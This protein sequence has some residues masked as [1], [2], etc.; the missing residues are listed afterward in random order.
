MACRI[1]IPNRGPNKGK[2][3]NSRLF[4]G[5]LNVFQDERKADEIYKRIFSNEFIDQFG[6]WLDFSTYEGDERGE[7]DLDINGEPRLDSLRFGGIMDVA[8]KIQDIEDNELEE[9]QIKWNQKTSDAQTISEPAALRIVERLE[10]IFGFKAK[11]INRRDKRWAGKFVADIPVINIAYMRADT[12]FHEFA[13]PWV[14]AI[15]KQNPALFESLKRELHNSPEGRAILKKVKDRYPQLGGNEY[16]KE[17]IVTAIGEYAAGMINE[18]GK[19]IGYAIFE[20]LKKIGKLINRIYNPNAIITPKDLSGQSLRSLATIMVETDAVLATEL[21]EFTTGPRQVTKR[22]FLKRLQKDGLV[23]PGH[24]QGWYG[25]WDTKPGETQI[26]RD[27]LAKNI[28]IIDEYVRAFPGLITRNGSNVTFDFDADPTNFEDNAQYQV[29]ED[30]IA[31]DEDPSVEKIVEEDTIAGLEA[32]RDTE[33]VRL[34][35]DESQYEGRSGVFNR[36][37]HFVK[38]NILGQDSDTV[39][40][41]YAAKRVFQRNRKNTESDSITIDKQEYTF[42]ELVDKFQKRSNNSAARG[43]AVHKIMEY[44]VTKDKRILKELAEIQKEKKDQDQITDQSLQWVWN[45]AEGVLRRIGVT[46]TDKMKAELMLHSPIL[47]IATQI[48]GLI[49]HDDGTLSMVDWKSGG[50]F[51]NDKVTTE[52]MRYSNGT[53][54]NVNNSKLSKAKLELAIRAIMVKEHMPNAKFRQVIVQHLDRNNPFK[55]PYEVHLHDYIKIVSNYLQAEK[56]EVYQRLKNAGLLEANEYTTTKVRN[57]AVLSKYQHLPLEEQI[58]GLEKEI[59]V[60]RTKIKTPGLSSNIY[61]DQELLEVLTNEYLELN[62]I[63]KESLNSEKDLGN[64]KTWASSIYNIASPRI[65]AFAKIFFR[66]TNKYQQRMEDE[67]KKSQKLFQAVK[68]EYMSENFGSQ[69]VGMA[70]LGQLS[71]YSY[72][73]AFS[74]AF[75]NR[76]DGVQTPGVYL[77]SLEDATKKRASGEMTKAQF[78]LLEHLHTT[79]NREWDTL[80][81]KKMESG[82]PYSKHVGMH[83]VENSV[84]DGKLHKNFMPRL[85]METGESYERYQ[86]EG[87]FVK[88]LKGTGEVINNFARNTFSLFLEENYYGQSDSVNA[89]IPVRF[90]GSPGIIADEMHSFNLEKMHYDFVGNLMRKQEMDFVVAL[91]DGLKSYY[92]TMARVK[93][94]DDKGWKNYENFM[95]NFLISSVMEERAAGRRDHWSSKQ[96]SVTNPFFDK[97]KPASLTNRRTFNISP[98]KIMMALK[99]I[100]TGKALFF[101]VIAGTFNGAIILMFT[102]M[103]GVQ[104]SIAKRAGYHPSAI[105]MTVSDLI[106]G[107]T[108]VAGYFKDQIVGAFTDKPSN[109]KLHN[110]LRR[111]KYLP[112]NYDYAIDQS[113]MVFLKN[114]GLSYDKLFFFHAIH[115]EWGHALMLAAQMRRIKMADGTSIWDS[116]NDD[117]TFMKTKN[118]KRNIRGVYTDP[119]GQKRILDELTED[120]LTRM[121]K[122]STDTHGAYRRHERML[123]EST[124]LGVWAVQFKK[125]LPALLIQEWESRRDDVHLGAY[126]E[127]T[128]KNGNKKKEKIEIDG[129]MVEMDTMDWITWQHEGRAKLLLKTIVGSLFGG[130]YTNYKWGNLNDRDKHDIIGIHSKFLVYFLMLFAMSGMDDDEDDAM[131]QRLV[132]LRK[133]ALQGLDPFELSRTVKNP[134]AVITHLNSMIEA[135]SPNS[136]RKDI[137]FLSIGYEMERYGLIER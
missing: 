135:S 98:F 123:L 5:L 87:F 43:R 93:Q 91:G 121:L 136:L 76:L 128:D 18:E 4:N 2:E 24:V 1:I 90:M 66:A 72:K 110:L 113:D 82:V 112:D 114:K 120:E 59:E 33:K 42:Q 132:Y 119:S 65:Q 31:V 25:I 29:I 106:W 118:G 53:L 124:S 26:D 117:G 137:P 49:Q 131:M 8:D 9:R 103:K 92:N 71:S 109:N 50:H 7:M 15:F 62:K 27:V 58:Q 67:K 17:A 64:F 99:H 16:Y 69:V 111:F 38:V 107:S 68:D 39:N 74:F 83:D 75:E 116:Y 96:L 56:P 13:H 41:E 88:Q 30:D 63:S 100:T 23:T 21:T 60:L 102:T 85:P 78:E 127:M 97:T 129:E 73:D 47:G 101:K 122:T 70:S 22:N 28:K 79:W 77:V 45:V 10:K 32:A 3:V 34:S 55:A 37:T 6:D 133:D 134:F 104:G 11:V 86:D 40:S 35:T 12:A 44:T 105:D 94:D 125:Y 52:M 54:D 14:D 126:W 95:E 115:E 19:G 84:V 20:L 36:L 51:L 108:K 81:S 57:S 89:H 80:M 61:E 48:D 46:S 130:Q